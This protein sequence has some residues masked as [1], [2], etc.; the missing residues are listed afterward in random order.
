MNVSDQ[1]PRPCVYW[2]TG[3]PGSGKSTIANDLA[4]ALRSTGKSA[5]VLDGDELRNGLNSDLGFEESD[6]HEKFSTS[7][8]SCKVAD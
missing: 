1:S 2:L 3:I 8:R 4:T 6:R 7:H 5:F